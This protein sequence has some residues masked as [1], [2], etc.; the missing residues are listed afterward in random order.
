MADEV[1]VEEAEE[2]VVA[3]EVAEEDTVVLV[4]LV[5]LPP[6]C[7]FCNLLLPNSSKS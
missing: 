3:M 5:V 4:G 7:E 6:E 2:A 1:V